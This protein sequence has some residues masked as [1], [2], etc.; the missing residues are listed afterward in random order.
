MGRWLGG[1][2][3]NWSKAAAFETAMAD[4]LMSVTAPAETSGAS[5]NQSAREKARIANLST[6]SVAVKSRPAT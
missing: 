5:Q 4:S 3:F 2:E 1:R 6:D